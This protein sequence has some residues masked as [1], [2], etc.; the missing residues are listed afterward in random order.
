MALFPFFVNIENQTG[1]IIGTGMHAREK[2][3]RLKP[4]GPKL[5]I[6]EEFADL[7]SCAIIISET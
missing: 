6:I 1:M 4:Y 2:I 7:L 3:E 5:K